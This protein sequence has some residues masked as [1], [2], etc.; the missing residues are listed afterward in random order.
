MSKN[1]PSIASQNDAVVISIPKEE[2]GNFLNDL[3]KSKRTV[4]RSFDHYYNIDKDSINDVYSIIDFRIKEQNSGTLLSSEITAIFSDG[5]RRKYDSIEYFLGTNDKMNAYS[6]GVYLNLSYMIQFS[7]EG[8]PLKQDIR[9]VV[10]SLARED[11]DE[12][13][14]VIPNT[15]SGRI[16]IDIKS[17]SFTWADD[18][19]SHIS[20]YLD[21]KFQRPKL[22]H[23]LMAATREVYLFLAFP[24]F[25]AVN[26]LLN[27]ET[28]QSD[29]LR[30]VFESNKNY[31]I[32]AISN[33]L[34][35]LINYQLDTG[36]TIKKAVP[37]AATFIGVILFFILISAFRFFLKGRYVSINEFSKAKNVAKEKRKNL[38]LYG[39]II[40]TIFSI[41]TGLLS[42]YIWDRI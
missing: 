22:W 27:G 34:D 2:F 13:F 32:V 20:N 41:G 28:S 4:G 9:F 12:I 19:I 7:L 38:I 31:D 14:G 5:S 40:A 36:M 3:L 39:I 23:R 33:K 10:N 25:F 16:S 26:F 18:V 24:A 1:L 30:K 29:T 15:V 35:G 6:T 42:S 37:L 21:S 17:N 8:P 11:G